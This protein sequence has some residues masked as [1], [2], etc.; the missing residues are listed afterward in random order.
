MIP[1]INKKLT[2]AATISKISGAVEPLRS[3]LPGRL[4]SW[5]FLAA[6]NGEQANL[7][8][9]ERTANLWKRQ[10]RKLQ[11]LHFVVAELWL[12]KPPSGTHQI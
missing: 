4:L 9:G 8:A 2:S 3:S 12:P 7:P 10:C 6:A 5:G 1:Y 11:P